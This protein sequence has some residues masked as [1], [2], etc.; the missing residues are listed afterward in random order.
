MLETVQCLHILCL[1]CEGP[2]ARSLCHKAHAPFSTPWLLHNAPNAFVQR[3]YHT[4]VNG[5]SYGKH[6]DS[7]INYGSF[8]TEVMST[9]TVL[10]TSLV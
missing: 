5:Y 8:V 3:L 7:L 9:D 10:F 2:A 1:W 4:S 6:S